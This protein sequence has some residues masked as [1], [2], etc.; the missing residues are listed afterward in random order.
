MFEPQHKHSLHLT[1]PLSMRATHGD[2]S[3]PC[4]SRVDCSWPAIVYFTNDCWVSHVSVLCSRFRLTPKHSHVPH[5]TPSRFMALAGTL[6]G[7][8]HSTRMCT[9]GFQH[10]CMRR[11]AMGWATTRARH[12]HSSSFQR[13]SRARLSLICLK[14]SH[15]FC[16]CDHNRIYQNS[17]IVDS[18]YLVYF[19]LRLYSLR[20][21]IH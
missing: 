8:W 15:R 21:R 13:K 17:I 9:S 5:D 12:A 11:G 16:R 20:D 6:W 1:S 18:I 10:R 4:H 19:E 14:S 3:V 2:L 7:N